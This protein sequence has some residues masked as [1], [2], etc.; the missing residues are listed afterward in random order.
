MNP[1]TA[2]AID[3][4]WTL[5]LDRDGVINERIIGGYVTSL[6]AFHFL[7]GAKEAI[8]TLSPF[9]GKIVV[10]TNQ[11]GIGKGL[12]THDDLA[13]IHAHMTR[14]V[15]QRGGKIDAVFYAPNLASEHSPLRKP[16]TGMAIEAQ[17]KFPEI[18]FTKSIMVGDTGSDMQFARS[19]GMKA[20][21]CG[22]EGDAVSA[23]VRVSSLAEFAAYISGQNS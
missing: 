3:N 8:A 12:Y 5:F 20:V 15:E 11:Q 19:A 16:A 6:D 23:D 22:A 10:V 4:T 17:R 9:F 21:F 18:D 7:P 14:E 2:F 1:F 13:A